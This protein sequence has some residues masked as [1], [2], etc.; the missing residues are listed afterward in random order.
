[1]T[2]PADSGMVPDEVFEGLKLRLADAKKLALHALTVLSNA[3]LAS[4]IIHE[5]LQAAHQANQD[6]M[7][8]AQ[9]VAWQEAKRKELAE[10]RRQDAEGVL[11]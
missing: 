10:S 3:P 5:R 11:Q 6:M 4:A 8:L 7:Q 9:L 1:M 2:N